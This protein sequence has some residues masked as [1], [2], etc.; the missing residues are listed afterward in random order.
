R[1]DHVD[2]PAREQ[3]EDRGAERHRHHHV[4]EERARGP[5][6]HRPRTTAGR[7]HE[8]REH[9]L[10]RQLTDE[11]HRKDRERD[12]DVHQRPL[13]RHRAGVA[14]LKPTTQS[15]YVPARPVRAHIRTLATDGGTAALLLVAAG[16][17]IVTARLATRMGA[18]PGTMGLGI[19]G[20]LGAWTSMM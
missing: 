11:D 4:D 18:M 16:A 15:T 2:G 20:F 17:W 19:I 8:R 10:V 5:E 9:R 12:P 14:R 6:P 3:R 1:D 13:T 7:E